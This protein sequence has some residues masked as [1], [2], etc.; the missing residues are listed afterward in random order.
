MSR[1]CSSKT[2]PVRDSVQDKIVFNANSTTKCRYLTECMHNDN[3]Q[4]TFHNT[5]R[6]LKPNISLECVNNCL[7]NVDIKQLLGE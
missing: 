6:I 5:S 7:E 4:I 2:G 3:E 1:V